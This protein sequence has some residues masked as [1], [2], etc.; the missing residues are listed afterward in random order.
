MIRE[1]EVGSISLNMAAGKELFVAHGPFWVQRKLGN[2]FVARHILVLTKT[3]ILF[4]R[5]KKG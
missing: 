2:I 1:L 4:V 5:K 3:R